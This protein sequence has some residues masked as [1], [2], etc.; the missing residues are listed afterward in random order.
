MDTDPP[1]PSMSSAD[2]TRCPT[3]LAEAL[4][5]EAM[6][7]LYVLIEQ[8]TAGEASPATPRG[9]PIDLAALRALTKRMP[10]QREDAGTFVRTMRE[11][12]RY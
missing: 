6:A 4:A 10:R 1:S 2:E 5:R 3:R 7:H 9:K 12:E 11:A 8:A